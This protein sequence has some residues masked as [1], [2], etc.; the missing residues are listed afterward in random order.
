MMKK[1]PFKEFA[2]ETSSWQYY[3][4]WHN[5]GFALATT[6]VFTP[7]LKRFEMPSE[8]Y[9]KKAF[10]TAERQIRLPAIASQKHLNSI[11]G[12]AAPV[13]TNAPN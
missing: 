7:D 5:E 4:A 11:F 10:A 1:H 9:Q 3:K 12:A 2:V 8:K 6:V 13:T